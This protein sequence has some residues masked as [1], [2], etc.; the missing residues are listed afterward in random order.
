MF[1]FAKGWFWFPISGISTSSLGHPL[2]SLASFLFLAY[3]FGMVVES[4]KLPITTGSD[5]RRTQVKRPPGC[6]GKIYLGVERLE[7]RMQK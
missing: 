7:K 2:P 5:Q 3:P 6:P 1:W 4:L